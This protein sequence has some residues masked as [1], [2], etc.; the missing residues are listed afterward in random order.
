LVDALAT[1]RQHY[2]DRLSAARAS[3]VGVVGLLGTT[4]PTEL[5]LATGRLPVQ[6]TPTLGRPTPDVDVYTEGDGPSELKALLQAAVDGAFAFLDLLILDRRHTHLFYY[7]KEVYR[8]G[9]GPGIPPLHLFDL[10]GSQRP[11]VRA[12]NWKQLQALQERLSGSGLTEAQLWDAIALTNRTRALQR[13]LLDRRWRGEVSGAVA[14]QALGAGAFMHPAEYVEVLAAWLA[15]LKP[16][17]ALE[18]RPRLLVLPSE[19]LAY[20]HL[21]RALEDAGALVVAEDD[22]W[23]SRGPGE[24]VPLAGSALEALFRKYWLDTAGPGVYPPEAREAW[25][26]QHALRTDV[27]GVV[28]YVPPSDRQFGWDYPRLKA[29][30]DERGKRSLLLRHDAAHADG[31]AAIVDETTAFLAGSNA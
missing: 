3:G 7:L 5:V 12:Y 25:F 17:A 26:V 30:L 24:D 28:F 2:D 18:G 23:G 15:E 20:A 16:D 1:L 31:R 6:I 27:D 13:Q 22:W 11:A 8:L 14:M 19:A 10:M 4:I 9:R 29:F 21:H